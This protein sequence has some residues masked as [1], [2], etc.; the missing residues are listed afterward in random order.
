VQITLPND[1]LQINPFNQIN[2]NKSLH[3]HSIK[4]IPSKHTDCTCTYRTRTL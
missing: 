2:P 3:T 1:I 4:Y